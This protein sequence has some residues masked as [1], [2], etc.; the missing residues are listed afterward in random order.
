MSNMLKIDELENGTC[1]Q[2]SALRIRRGGASVRGNTVKKTCG[3]ESVTNEASSN[4]S[5]RIKSINGKVV[6]MKR[7]GDGSRACMYPGGRKPIDFGVSWDPNVMG[8]PAPAWPIGITPEDYRIHAERP[9][10]IVFP[11]ELVLQEPRFSR[12][13]SYLGSF[14]S[15]LDRDRKV[16]LRSVHLKGT[17]HGTNLLYIGMDANNQII[18]LAT[19]VS[20][21]K[22]K[23]WYWKTCKAYT[24]PEFKRSISGI[25]ALRPEAYKNLKMLGLKGGQGLIALQTDKTTSHQ[26]VQNQSMP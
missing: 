24:V 22:L 4:I 11:E 17:Y 25:K 19:G 5:N 9:E 16:G 7:K 6:R 2:T 3:S 1:A 18:P 10:L 26:T 15:L 21:D 13:G 23:A 20:Q 12:S 14:S 8:L